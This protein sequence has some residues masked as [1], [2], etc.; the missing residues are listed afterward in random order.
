MSDLTVRQDAEM[1]VLELIHALQQMPPD[2]VIY[3]LG[4]YEGTEITDSGNSSFAR[5]VGTCGPDS[6]YIS[7]EGH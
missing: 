2:A 7:Q 4:V 3:L 5:V 1:T 6:C